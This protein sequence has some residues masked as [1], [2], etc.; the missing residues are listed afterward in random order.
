MY[1]NVSLKT[2]NTKPKHKNKHK[3]IIEK[4]TNTKTN[5]KFYVKKSQTFPTLSRNP[6]NPNP[7]QTP[8]NN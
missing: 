1:N 7:K 3:N 8:H 2:Q 5:I 4:I 6:E